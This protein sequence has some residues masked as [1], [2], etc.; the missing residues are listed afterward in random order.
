VTRYNINTIPVKNIWYIMSIYSLDQAST[1]L[2]AFA[3]WQSSN[4]DP[5]ASVVFLFSLQAITFGLIYNEHRTERPAAFQQF[6]GLPSP[7][8]TPV[9][10]SNGTVFILNQITAAGATGQPTAP[11]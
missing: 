9:P 6:S 2:D 5:K 3:A 1:I 4:T 11:R 10:E 7:L 8:M